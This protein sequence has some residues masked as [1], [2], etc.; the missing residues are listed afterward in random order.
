MRRLAAPRG[1]SSAPLLGVLGALLLAWR[2]S[3]EAPVGGRTIVAAPQASETVG[4]LAAAVQAARAGDVIRLEPG[5]YAESIVVPEGVSLR[6]RVPGA[7]VFVRPRECDRRVG[8]AR[9]RRR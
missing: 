9:R 6:A 8:G 7:S 4:T 2:L 1:S 3:T 5:T